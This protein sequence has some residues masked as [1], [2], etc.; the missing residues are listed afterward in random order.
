MDRV[1]GI[2]QKNIGLKKLSKSKK[3]ITGKANQKYIF[4]AN[5]SSVDHNGPDTD[6]L[7]DKDGNHGR[8]SMK[9][10]QG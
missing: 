8:P 7:K 5:N 3:K 1:H 9:K 6:R 10:V 4:S 2:G